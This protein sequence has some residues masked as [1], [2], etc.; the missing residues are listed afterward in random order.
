MRAVRR[1]S[2]PS[3]E[4]ARRDAPATEVGR[5][6][7]VAE[8]GGSFC[9]PRGVLL[10]GPGAVAH[11]RV[12]QAVRHV[13]G[14]ER[15]RG[16]DGRDQRDRHQ[17]RH[18]VRFDRAHRLVADPRHGEDL[19]HDE[20]SAEQRRKLQPRERHHRQHRVPQRVHHHLPERGRPLGLCRSHVVLTNRLQHRRALV[21]RERRQ[22]TDHQRHHRQRQPPERLGG[23]P[24]V[25]GPRDPVRRRVCVRQ[26]LRR[27]ERRQRVHGEEDDRQRHV[28]RPPAPPR[29]ERAEGYR[30]GVAREEREERQ[31]RE[32]DRR[33]RELVG[34]RHAV[35]RAR[36]EA[37]G[38]RAEDP[39]AVAGVEH[40]GL[41]APW[42]VVRDVV[43]LVHLPPRLP[44][45]HDAMDG[46]V[47]GVERDGT[48]PPRRVRGERGERAE[49]FA[50][51]GLAHRRDHGGERVRVHADEVAFAQVGR[52]QDESM[53]GAMERGA[54]EVE[55]AVLPELRPEEDRRARVVELLRG[56][57]PHSLGDRRER[58]G[59]A[60]SLGRRELVEPRE[61]ERERRTAQ[62]RELDAA[63]LRLR[64][65]SEDEVRSGLLP[66]ARD[67]ARPSGR[68]LK[69]AG[70]SRNRTRRF[71][72]RPS[73]VAG[74]RATS[75]AARRGRS[76]A[77]SGRSDVTKNTT[78]LIP[79]S[80]GMAHSILRRA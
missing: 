70:R 75:A 51:V 7:A 52:M 23:V 57:G 72:S 4:G 53:H 80:V 62:A 27:P 65:S 34:D 19:L 39:L 37:T 13:A 31:E 68:A 67:F 28:H 58:D 26:E 50:V 74:S 56:P 10:A 22:R 29:R 18:V 71:S 41:D 9:P 45:A 15:E 8:L 14:D 66:P 40:G 69:N 3:V 17:P 42:T 59:D 2:W 32:R 38:R 55:R 79:N 48:A 1:W 5:R 76:A 12:E 16:D 6:S 25:H 63:R 44:V 60:P 24:E 49:G 21:P 54:R 46:V 20:R 43:A 73:Y 64:A 61:D 35:D 33:A 36:S 77:G 78:R 30:N 47:V 11:A